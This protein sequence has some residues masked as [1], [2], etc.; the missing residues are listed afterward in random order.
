MELFNKIVPAV[1]MGIAVVNCIVRVHKQDV[2]GTILW[3][4]WMICFTILAV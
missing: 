2:C 3:A 4:A 1:G